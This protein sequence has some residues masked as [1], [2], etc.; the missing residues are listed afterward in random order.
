[1][2]EMGA[3]Q[4][5]Q[6]LDETTKQLGVDSSLDAL[7]AD[8]ESSSVYKTRSGP[9]D[10]PEFPPSIEIMLRSEQTVLCV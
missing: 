1:M 3:G 8:D 5:E 4:A 2:K 7:R 10:P 6:T 9:E